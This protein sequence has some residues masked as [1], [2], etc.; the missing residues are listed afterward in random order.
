MNLQIN[1][2][3][4]IPPAIT[5]EPFLPKPGEILEVHVTL[6]L[7][8]ILE[9][10]SLT[11]TLTAVESGELILTK[12]SCLIDETV[13]SFDVSFE[14]PPTM[15]PGFYKLLVIDL[16]EERQEHV[17]S[18]EL[19]IIDAATEE[20]FEF[21]EAGLEAIMQA[22]GEEQAAESHSAAML[23]EKAGGYY[24]QAGSFTCAG[25]ALADSVYAWHKLGNT[26][27][28][29]NLAWRATELL[30][31]AEDSIS[32]APLLS[33]LVEVTSSVPDTVAQYVERSACLV[34]RCELEFE[35]ETDIETKR[36][37]ILE[38]A[39]KAFPQAAGSRFNL[40]ALIDAMSASRQNIYL[41]DIN[42]LISLATCE[43][44]IY[45]P[46]VLIRTPRGIGVR[47][48]TFVD[49]FVD[50]YVDDY[51]ES[52]TETL[53]RAVARAGAAYGY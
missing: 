41:P 35:S 52:V 15:A 53:E 43:K 45:R 51:H 7:G 49:E 8:Q 34:Q 2:V 9:P 36:S 26:D 29:I 1:G 20:N 18:E 46:G 16:R 21:S 33:W 23:L 37:V 17:A 30:I 19:I 24:E 28:A 10:T 31:R 5:F 40:Q 47:C 44:A 14:L 48:A 13:E 32:A 27:K 22:V 50:D 38:V 25:L 6:V 4:R 11:V 12:H 3:P 39:R 42:S